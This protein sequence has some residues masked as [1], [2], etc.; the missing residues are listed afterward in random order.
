MGPHFNLNSIVTFLAVA[1]AGSF[2]AA[3]ERLH[4]SASAVS[5]R[6]KLLET[7]LGVKLFDRTTRSVALTEAGRRLLDAALNACAALSSVEKT[8]RQEASLQRGEVTIAVVP[9]LAQDEIPFLLADFVR[10]Y[11]GIK[12]NLLD[13]DSH[14]SLQ[15]LAAAEVDLAIVSEPSDRKN[16]VFEPLYWDA[17]SLVVPKGHPLG[18]KTSVALRELKNQPL[19]VNPQGTLL[20]KVLQQAFLD[21][22]LALHD[23]AQQ[24]ST[25]PTLVRMVEAGFGLG[26]APAQALRLVAAGRCELIS[27]KGKVGWTV[28]IARMASRY[29]A[30]AS[31][32]LRDM[33]LQRY[34]QAAAPLAPMPPAAVRGG[35]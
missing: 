19:M 16:V 9:S 17:C 27:L 35:G 8:L 3:S 29:E 26:I 33:L 25:V 32:A 15:M 13:I 10:Q 12:V 31:A 28:G 1:Q 4:T 11:P 34:A 21:A 18:K 6:I 24:I 22:D 14:R 30:P 5:A 20:R 7:R 2:R 23:A